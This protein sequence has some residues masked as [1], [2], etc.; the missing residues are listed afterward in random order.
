[1]LWW[2]TQQLRSEDSKVRERAARKLGDSQ[3]PRAVESLVAALAD[4]DLN[5]RRTAMEGLC[6]TTDA[7]ADELLLV[8]LQDTDTE[9]QQA[10][11]LMTIR[12][13]GPVIVV[14]DEADAGFGDQRQMRQLPQIRVGE[15][16]ETVPAPAAGRCD[17]LH[18][19][20]QPARQRA[21]VPDPDGSGERAVVFPLP[22]RQAR[23]LR[24]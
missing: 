15:V 19:L 14:V 11:I 18:G 21:A 17:V 3:N 9:V 2:T 12:A 6:K 10:R 1:M 24:L 8:A 22:Q 23:A 7:R 13:L 5:V 20:S 4:H 16:P